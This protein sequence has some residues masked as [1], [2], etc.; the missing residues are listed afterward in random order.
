[1]SAIL[2][3]PLSTEELYQLQQ[4]IRHTQEPYIQMLVDLYARSLPTITIADGV[5]QTDYAPEVERRAGEIRLEMMKAM[6]LVV[7]YDFGWFMTGA[8]RG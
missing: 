2:D 8:R 7:R 4:E 3:R 1:M 6:E 5:V